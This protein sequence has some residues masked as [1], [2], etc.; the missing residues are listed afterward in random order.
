MNVRL[1][2]DTL[3]MAEYEGGIDPAVNARVVAL[4]DA[5]RRRHIDGV[6][7]VVPGYASL[8]IHFDPLR[9]DLRELERALRTEAANVERHD[10]LPEPRTVEIPVRY[11]GADGPDLAEVARFAGCSTSKVVELHAATVYHVYML[12]F[13]PGFAYLGRVPPA[14]A[15]PRHRVPRDRVPPGSVGIAGQQT[16][17]YPIETPGGWQLIGRTA[18]VMFD[19]ERDPASLLAPGDTVRFVPL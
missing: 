6:R 13:V 11:G 3:L 17:V 18:S 16:G 8:G 9:T 14:I 10:G 2:G 15:A 12:G 1:A 5:L 7:D 19:V 4:G